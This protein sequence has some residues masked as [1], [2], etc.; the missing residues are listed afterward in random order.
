[1]I[2]GPTVLFSCVAGAARWIPRVED[3]VFSVRRFGGSCSDAPFVVNF[4]GEIPDRAG[5]VLADL[6]ADART[7]EP[8][9][10]QP[11]ANKLRMLDLHRSAEFEVLVALDCD[12]VVVADPRPQIPSSAIGAKPADSDPFTHRDWRRLYGPRSATS[13]VEHAGDIDGKANPSLFQQRRPD[14]PS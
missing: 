10:G 12:T 4:V 8:I 9:P 3:L 11:T 14:R 2:P 6:G 7:V 13:V 5:R 1:M